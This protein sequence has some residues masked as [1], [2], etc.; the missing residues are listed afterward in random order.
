MTYMQL[1]IDFGF[2]LSSVKDIVKADGDKKKIGTITG[3]TIISK[4]MLTVAAAA[5]M[6]GICIFM[7]ELRA[8]WLF[9]LFSFVSV[10]TSIFLLDFLFRGIEKMQYITYIFLI[11]K[12][13][14]TALTFIWVKNDGDL[15]LIPLLEILANVISATISIGILNKLKFKIYFG[16]IK[17]CFQMIKDSFSYFL[18]NVA[19]TAFSA[20]NTLI[21]GIYMK[22]MTQVGHWS[23]C[24]SMVSAIQGLYSPICN[25]VYPHMIKEKSLKFIHKTMLLIMPVVTAG[26]VFSF[27]VARQA[28]FVI[29]DESYMVA[30]PVFRCMIPILFFSFPAQLYGWPT[31]GA[32]GKVKETTV[33]TVVSAVI[34]IIG[35][36]VLIVTNNFNLITLALV[37]SFTE[38]CLMAIRMV[39]VYVNRKSFMVLPKQ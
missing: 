3:N 25:G 21:L 18:S 19:T 37:R 13:I 33:S 17:D 28:L 38:F 35:L 15:I 2:I 39:I 32:I 12:T 26:C 16:S 34:Q 29:G 1:F 20:L 7:S 30:A 22:D 11:T 4:A 14:T 27:F 24:L 9:V 36:V 31:L 23:V 6:F 10:A 5:V 8:N